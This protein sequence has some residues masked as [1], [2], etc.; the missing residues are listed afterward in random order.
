MIRRWNPDTVAAPL[1]AYS[2]LAHVPADHELVVM[3]GQI[4]V[5]PE[6]GL[7][8]ED[9]TAQTEAVYANIERLLEAAGA[10]PRQLV[11][12]FSMVASTEHLPGYRAAM[13]EVFTR[14]FPDGDWPAHSMIVVAALAKPELL[15]EVE[16]L[17]ALPR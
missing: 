12:V 14:W 16:A 3:A 10:G 1:G 13:R 6:G 17:A 2:H 15:V 11:K 8:G 5:L 4:G 9:V 7:A